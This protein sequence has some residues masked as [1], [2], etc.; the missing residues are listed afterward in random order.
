VR[1]ATF[2]VLHGRS[3]ADDRV[4]ADRF[5]AAV[6][7]L[8]ADLLG[9]QEVDR[10]QPRSGC[11]DL[12]AIAAEAGGYQA[13]RFAPALVGEPGSWRQATGDEGDAPAYGVALLSRYPV[14]DWRVVRLPALRRRV[15][16]VFKGP[17]AAIVTDEPRV[18]VVAAVDAPGGPL[19]I[20]VTHLS[21]LPGWNVV[22]LRHLLREIGAAQRLVLMG[23]LHMRPL[24]AARTSGLRPLAAAPTFPAHAPKVQIDHLL[25][26]GDVV[27]TGPGRAV[28]LPLSDH[29]ALAV[30]VVDGG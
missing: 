3:P 4:D 25:G 13:W 6:A 29:C 8:D 9:L 18:A 10:A 22:Q 5:A 24:L 12:T 28:R 30:T 17:R 2:N 16:M 15:P 20:A 26:R 14:R 1:L 7:E 19:A 27:P 23:D 21:F 11:A